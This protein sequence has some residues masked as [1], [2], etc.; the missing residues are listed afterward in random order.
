MIKNTLRY[1]R[2]EDI[3]MIA[4]KM[5]GTT[6]GLSLSDIASELK[7]SRRT[8]ERIRDS[9]LR[10]FPQTEC[11]YTGEKI[12]RWKIPA[13]TLN[14]MINFSSEELADLENMI[15]ISSQKN[16]L[17]S[18]KNLNKLKNKILALVSNKKK[19]ALEADLEILLESEN[20]AMKAGPCIPQ[21]IKYV[22]ILRDAIKGAN[23]IKV[24]YHNKN[25]KVYPYGFIYGDRQYLLSYDPED[26]KMKLFLISDIKNVEIVKS[27]FIRDEN[28]SLEKYAE[29]S[30][31]VFQ[32]E[33][34]K[35]VWRFSK[36]VVNDAK[37]FIFHPTQ[38]TEFQKDG[39]LI[40][41]FK[42]GGLQEMCRHLFTWGEYV[43]I[44]EPEILKTEYQKMLQRC[45]NSL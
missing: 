2:V 32:E 4:Y 8:A 42:A 20:I 31:G 9:I 17:E 21:N 38:K 1:S 40:V 22:G 10:I 35:V 36:E 23:I 30:F 39:S 45:I 13:G 28:F 5:Q 6:E 24:N 34:F 7:V 16:F 33:S 3:L 41:E 12:K 27:Y 11:V 18:V 14:S 26:K 15:N 37:D 19:Y 43:E 44:I 25:R 29:N